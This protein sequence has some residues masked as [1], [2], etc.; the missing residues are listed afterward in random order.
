VVC[1]LAGMPTTVGLYVPWVAQEAHR[2][3]VCMEGGSS[4][5]LC[6][7]APAFAQS[8]SLAAEAAARAAVG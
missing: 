5:L 3:T 7:L 6:R 2:A 1:I 8:L 4:G